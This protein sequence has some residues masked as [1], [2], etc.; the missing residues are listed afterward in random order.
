M[1]SQQPSCSQPS[2]STIRHSII[3]YDIDSLMVH[4]FAVHSLPLQ[5]LQSEVFINMMI[6]W[7]NTSG[8]LPTAKRMRA[9]Y[10]EEANKMKQIVVNKM[11]ASKLTPVTVAADGWTNTC[12]EKVINIIPVCGGV[13][14]YSTIGKA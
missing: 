4:A 12:H 1:V 3:D 10:H 13:A 14:Y 7:R 2:T 5:I 9:M 11:K 8:R 6:C